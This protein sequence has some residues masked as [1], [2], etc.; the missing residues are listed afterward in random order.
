MAIVSENGAEEFDLQSEANGTGPFT[1]ESSDANSTVL[2]AFEDHWDGAPSIDGVE[3]RYITEPTAALTAL[4]NGEVQWTDNVPP[5]NIES[6]QDDDSVE[7]GSVTSVE[8]YYLTMN[9]RVPPFDNRDVRRAIATAVDRE[10]VT[11]A[12]RRSEERR[13]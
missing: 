7:L 5:Q 10:E 13:G 6:L 12:A 4:S 8:Y 2:A 3:F 11:Q 1:L 9:Y